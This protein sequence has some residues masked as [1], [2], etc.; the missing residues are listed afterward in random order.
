MELDTNLMRKEMK[1]VAEERILNGDFAKE[2]TALD[3]EG[4]GVQKK[5]EE[6]YE[7]ASH[8]ELAQGEARVRERLGLKTI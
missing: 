5:L 8:S 6:L 7:R 4:P 3:Q 1:R 2:F